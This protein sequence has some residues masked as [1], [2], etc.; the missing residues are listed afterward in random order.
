MPP[1]PTV[2]E[3]HIYEIANKTRGPQR[4]M[5]D[6]DESPSNW[7]IL[8]KSLTL[9]EMMDIALECN[10]YYFLLFSTYRSW[11]VISQHLLRDFICEPHL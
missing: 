3:N 2:S 6:F 9:L 5:N 10:K 8:L 7:Y 11:F 4:N 1:L